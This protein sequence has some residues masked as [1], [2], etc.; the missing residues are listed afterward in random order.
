MALTCK[1]LSEALSDSIVGSVTSLAA[2]SMLWILCSPCSSI[3]DLMAMCFVFVV[4]SLLLLL[5]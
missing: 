5:F 3:P 4:L 1:F 2:G